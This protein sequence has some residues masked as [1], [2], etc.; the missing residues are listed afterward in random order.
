MGRQKCRPPSSFCLVQTPGEIPGP[1]EGRSQSLQ[2]AACEHGRSFG[3]EPGVFPLSLFS[4]LAL[5]LWFSPCTGGPRD[6]ESTM[7]RKSVLSPRIL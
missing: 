1:W 6:T 3:G 2:S 5:G 4:V 7:R